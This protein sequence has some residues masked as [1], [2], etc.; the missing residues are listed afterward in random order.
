MRG[1]CDD[2]GGSVLDHLKLMERFSWEAKEGRD[3]A[4]RA[5]SDE[6]VDK[7]RGTVGGEEEEKAVYGAMAEIG[8]EEE[9]EDFGESRFGANK[10]SFGSV[11][12]STNK[13]TNYTT[14]F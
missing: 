12:V 1:S 5:G 13:Q 6:E 8:G 7:N 10:N 2:T 4:V 14:E 11:T 9:S 3:A